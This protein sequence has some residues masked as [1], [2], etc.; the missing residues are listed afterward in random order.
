MVFRLCYFAF[1]GTR[2]IRIRCREN[3]DLHGFLCSI[4]VRLSEAEARVPIGAP[5]MS[6]PL[7]FLIFQNPLA[8]SKQS[9]IKTALSELCANLCALCG[10]CH[11]ILLFLE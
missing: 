5:L 8:I 9:E 6:L 3:A 10:K 1:N 2:M 4:F 11:F 7:T